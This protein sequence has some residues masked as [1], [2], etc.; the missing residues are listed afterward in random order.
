MK[1]II[2]KKENFEKYK[3]S[4]ENS[5]KEVMDDLNKQYNNLNRLI[6]EKYYQNENNNVFQKIKE[7][8]DK[9]IENVKDYA[10]DSIKKKNL[11][12]NDKLEQINKIK[13]ITNEAIIEINELTTFIVEQSYDLIRK[14]SENK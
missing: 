4:I 12:E 10:K 7:I 8:L 3:V 5:F 9:T 6:Q 11:N 14:I 1:K 2:N 13:T